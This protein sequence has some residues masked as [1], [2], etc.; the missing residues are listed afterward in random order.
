VLAAADPVAAVQDI[1]DDMARG[2]RQRRER[3]QR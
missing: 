1:I 3:N 2:A